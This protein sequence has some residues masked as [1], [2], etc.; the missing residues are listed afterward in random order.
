MFEDDNQIKMTTFR[1]VNE[2]IIEENE[3]GWEEKQTFKDNHD[4]DEEDNKSITEK[5]VE[6][7]KKSNSEEE[8]KS[9]TEEDG[10]TVEE[11]KNGAAATTKPTPLPRTIK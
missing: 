5:A 11:E 4:V 1:K 7:E 3:V 10:A 9:I 8:K 2:S 6:E